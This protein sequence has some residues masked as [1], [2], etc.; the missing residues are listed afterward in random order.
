MRVPNS[1]AAVYDATKPNGY[2][3]NLENYGVPPDVW[4]QNSLE[5]ERKHIDRELEAAI[6]EVMRTLKPAVSP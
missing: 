3:I 4:V 5:D 6:D 1:L 2:G